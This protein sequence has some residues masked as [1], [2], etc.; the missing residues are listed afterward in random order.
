MNWLTFVV[1]WLHVLLGILWFGYSLA[2]AVFFIP[3]ISPLPIPVQRQVGE[4]LAKRATPILDMV[5]PLIVL[6]GFIRGTL[7]GPIHSIGYVFSQAYGITWL[8]GLSAAVATYL[9]GRLVIVP[10]VERMAAIP[11]G[12][13]GGTTP[14]LDAAVEQAKRVTVV[15]LLGFFIIFSCMILMRFGL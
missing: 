14:E 13:D 2:L 10:T 5:V 11:L 7:L 6:L 1:Q 8:V 4:N 3:A 15:E 9:W 12:A